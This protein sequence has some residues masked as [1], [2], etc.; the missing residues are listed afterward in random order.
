V[1]VLYESGAVRGSAA[2]WEDCGDRAGCTVRQLQ[3]MVRGGE[4]VCVQSGHDKV[5]EL[6]MLQLVGHALAVPLLPVH[7]PAR[8][9]VHPPARLPVHPPARLPVHPPA[10]LCTP[11]LGCAPPC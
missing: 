5:V 9:P 3:G 2:V 7:P 10:R 4:E 11:L 1:G 6:G 8:L